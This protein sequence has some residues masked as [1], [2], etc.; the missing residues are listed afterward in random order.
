[1]AASST[2]SVGVIGGLPAYD[3]SGKLL[4]N[5]VPDGPWTRHPDESYEGVIATNDYPAN[6]S[7]ADCRQLQRES[8]KYFQG[9]KGKS[10]ELV[11]VLPMNEPF[12]MGEIMLETMN[13]EELEKATE[14][15][16]VY[17]HL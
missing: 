2:S 16:F 14:R 3:E 8:D 13:G 6:I 4:S 15:Q 10:A 1:M 11:W 9:L 5:K 7:I 12:K 17:T